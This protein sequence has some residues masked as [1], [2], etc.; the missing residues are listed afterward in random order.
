MKYPIPQRLYGGVLAVGAAGALLSRFRAAG[1]ARALWATAAVQALVALLAVA[2]GWGAAG[3]HWPV[4]I[5]V[6]NGVF[7]VLFGRSALLFRQAA[8][9]ESPAGRGSSA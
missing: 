1:M 9:A 3:P 5:L 2:A 6:L 4:D 7:V 8:Q